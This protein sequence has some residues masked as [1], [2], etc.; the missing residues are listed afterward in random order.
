MTDKER[1]SDE[2][3]VRDLLGAL[4]GHEGGQFRAMRERLEPMLTRLRSGQTL[5]DQDLA[6]LHEEWQRA[7]S[8]RGIVRL[9]RGQL[10][11]E[12]L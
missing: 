12:T 6:W 7:A 8:G 11:D 2:E 9:R 1:V 3:R 4:Q 10:F 5:S